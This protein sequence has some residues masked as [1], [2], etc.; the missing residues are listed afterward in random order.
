MKQNPLLNFIL[1]IYIEFDSFCVC[2]FSVFSS[3]G[4]NT[5]GS[6]SNRLRLG[7]IK[8]KSYIDV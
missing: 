8:H 7:K 1:M 6:L 5:T 4:P 3:N 2:E